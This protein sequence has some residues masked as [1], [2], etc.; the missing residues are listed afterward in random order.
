MKR[1]RP[2]RHP[3]AGLF[4]R[5]VDSLGAS[6]AHDTFRGYHA[7]VKDF[8]NYLGAEYRQLCSVEQLRRDP[9]ILGWLAHLRSKTPPLV[10]G[11]HRN[12]LQRLHRILQELA[13][14]E[15]IPELARLLRPE[16]SPRPE[17]RLPRPLVA[18][19]DQ[20]IQQELLRRN[21]LASNFLLLLRHTGMR[22][23]ECADLSYD[24]LRS[25]GPDQ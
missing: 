1:R 22:I 12:H 6:F 21:D 24:C 13:W 5:A 3:M 8:L 11:T 17:H 7:T 4:L 15:Q 10:L 25:N 14:T 20:S 9:H 23:G 18:A 16:D 19:Q 2:L